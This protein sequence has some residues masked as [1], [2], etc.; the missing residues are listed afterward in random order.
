[1]LLCADSNLSEPFQDF[2]IEF[3]VDFDERGTAVQDDFH[4]I[5]NEEPNLIQV[6]NFASSLPKSL[7]EKPGQLAPIAYRGVGHKVSGRNQ[8][9]FPVLLGH[10]TSYSYELADKTVL[11]DNPIL[12]SDVSLV[13]AF[14]A[15]NNARVIFAGS[16][17][18]F[19]NE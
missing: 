16:V 6:S 9:A 13:T 5:E 19:K 4:V 14:Q 1:M 3:S 2:S 7:I 11:R 8:L 12:G 17:D 18:M 15:K 10:P